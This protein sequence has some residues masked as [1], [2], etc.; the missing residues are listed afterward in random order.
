MRV[1]VSGA[2]GLVGSALLRHLTERDLELVRIVRERGGGGIF[3]SPAE[4]AIDAEALRG[5]G[6]VVH[7][8]GE[9]VG[10]GRWT[11]E[12][13]ARIRDSRIQGTGFLARAIADMDD[14]P[15]VLVCAS[16]A[17]YYGDRGDEELDEESGPG[18]GFLAEVSEGWEAACEP[19]RE[20]GV[21]VVSLRI[22]LVLSGD[23]GALPRMMAPFRLG[24]GGRIGD[25]RQWV[26]FIA[27]DDLVRII[28]RAID[29]PALAGPVNAVAPSA[30]TNAELTRALGA[31]LRRPAVLPVPAA[32][33]RLAL[34]REM[35]DAL[36]LSSQRV[37]PRRL[38]ET[39]FEWKLPE[40]EGALRHVLAS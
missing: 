12:Q 36:L 13:K 34:G 33:V 32:A 1:A 4:G 19:A 7:L 10:A 29:D 6:A 16:A 37:V 28:E 5:V 15:E 23:G 21:R 18:Q 14:R 9:S 40:L 30:V 2:S 27:I 35:A 17:G 38:R 25:G 26:S 39:G 20:A 3:F 24:L 11:P 31:V 8:A 22:G